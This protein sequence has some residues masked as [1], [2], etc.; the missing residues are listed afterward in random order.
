MGKRTSKAVKYV[1]SM[2]LWRFS[3]SIYLVPLT[4]TLSTTTCT[5]R[6]IYPMS[7]NKLDYFMLHFSSTLLV[8]M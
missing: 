5:N 4:N 8:C 3:T 1:S 7:S 6:M 2:P